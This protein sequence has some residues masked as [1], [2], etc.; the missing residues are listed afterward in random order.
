MTFQALTLATLGMLTRLRAAGV[1]RSALH[2]I[3]RYYNS[4]TFVVACAVL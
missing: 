2:Q 1:S 4:V 3:S